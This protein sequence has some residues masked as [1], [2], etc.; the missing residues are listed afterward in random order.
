[1]QQDHFSGWQVLGCELCAAGQYSESLAAFD[2]ALAINPRDGDTWSFRGN[3]LSALQRPAEALNSYDK[4]VAINAE[5]HQ[6]WFN[7]GLLLAEMQAY[8]LAQ[9]AYDQAI[10]LHPDPRYL[11][12]KA[13]IWLKRKLVAYPGV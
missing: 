5:H 9:A 11:H 6:A 3:A 10:A 2:R 13:E 8:G 4:A 12:A 7:R 1:M